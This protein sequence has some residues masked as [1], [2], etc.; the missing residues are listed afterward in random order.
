MKPTL[1]IAL[2]YKPEGRIQSRVAPILRA[3]LDRACDEDEQI[4]DS[5]LLDGSFRSLVIQLNNQSSDFT[6]Q[7]IKNRNRFFK[8]RECH[9]S[10]TSVWYQFC[11]S[12]A[13]L[14]G[15]V[16]CFYVFI[17]KLLL[18]LKLFIIT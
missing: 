6:L 13:K 5:R 18:I 4:F 1:A 9:P 15:F 17:H 12:S 7:R 11:P 14:L 3:S 2:T 16:F 10:Q 8:L